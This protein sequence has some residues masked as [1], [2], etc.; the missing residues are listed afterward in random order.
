MTFAQIAATIQYYEETVAD[1]KGL[2]D[3]FS[4]HEPFPI[5]FES[6][7]L[8]AEA[9]TRFRYVNPPMPFDMPLN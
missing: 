2:I 7:P 6:D 1:Y 9:T 5:P 4:R 8:D 3:E